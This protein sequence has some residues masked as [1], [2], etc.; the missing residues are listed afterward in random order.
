M[1][2]SRHPL[3]PDSTGS[4]IDFITDHV[5]VS[6]HD[7]EEMDDD[8]EVGRE[9][10]GTQDLVSSR[11]DLW[12][13]I[14]PSTRLGWIL[15]FGAGLILFSL[16]MWIR[17]TIPPWMRTRWFMILAAAAGGLVY[18]WLRTRQQ[19]LDYWDQFDQVDI[20]KGETVEPIVGEVEPAEDD[21]FVVKELESVGFAGLNPT[22]RRVDDEFRTDDALM[23][24]LDRRKKD[25]EW[26]EAH[27]F[28]DHVF[29]GQAD[30]EHFGR[31]FVAHSG[32]L[33]P[34][35]KAPN[36]EWA[37]TP[38]SK[39]DMDAARELIIRDEQF[40]NEVVP[41]LMERLETRGDRL[42][43]LREDEMDMPLVRLDEI[44]ELLAMVANAFNEE[45]AA[46]NGE[47]D[48][49]IKLIDETT[50]DSLVGD[51]R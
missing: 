8:D 6:L 38:P 13:R 51:G 39:P 45:D 24:K 26:E 49:A 29:V 17:P 36:H 12:D 50:Q 18:I 15:A 3:L 19:M 30:T 20:Y 28:L 35:P 33:K 22:F 41:S 21:D 5:P 16:L 4:S 32:R 46:K 9:M 43:K 1:S 2:S 7:R 40:R 27:G 10:S 48:S 31:R 47:S 25:G 11:D 23:N 44:P 42:D 37:T 14:T 34:T